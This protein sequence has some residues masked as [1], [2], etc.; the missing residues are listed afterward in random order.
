MEMWTSS[1]TST[2]SDSPR[3]SLAKRTQGRDVTWQALTY[4]GLDLAE[5]N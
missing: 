4:H 2:S 1:R 3:T 5:H